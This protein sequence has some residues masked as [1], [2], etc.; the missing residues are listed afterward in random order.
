MAY[1]RTLKLN[2]N[3]NGAT[4]LLP[5]TPHRS[6]TSADPLAGGRKISPEEAKELL[7]KMWNEIDNCAL[8][9]E[10]RSRAAS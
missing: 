5:P 4:R 3:N 8:P 7:T 6:W 9:E 2:N 1:H 10:P